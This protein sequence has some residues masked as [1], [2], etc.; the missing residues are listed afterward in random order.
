[1]PS[2]LRLP[3]VRLAGAVL[4]ISA[5]LAAAAPAAPTLPAV[6]AA[7]EQVLAAKEV[8]GAV[9]VV[10]TKDRVLHAGASGLA[11]LAEKKPMPEDAL[12]WIASVSKMV[13]GAAILALQ[14]EGRLKLGDPVAKYLPEFAAL[15]TPS[16][17]PANLTIAQL[18][19][20]T[21]GLAETPRALY[22][23]A[24]SLAEAVAPLATL[25]M[26]FEPEARWKYTTSGFDVAG[27]IAEAVTGQP[28]DRF[29]AARITGPLGMKDTTFFPTAEQ[30]A[31]LA[32]C[33]ARN[34]TTGELDF[35]PPDAAMFAL[36]RIPLPGGGLFSTA[37]DLGRFCQML[38]G[39][40]AFG[41]RRILSADAVAAL[42][43]V[44]TGDLATGYSGGQTNQ[45]LGWGA[46]VYVVR[47]PAARGVSAAL[48]PGAYGHPGAW[49]THAIVDP[50]RGLAYVLMVQRPNLPDNFENEPTRALVA[51]ATAA[52]KGP[53]D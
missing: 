47:T 2:A 7:M 23:T 31:R 32:S 6:S 29:L 34:R 33:Y 48:G 17:Q 3:R 41:G 15:R 4:L 53:K 51:A 27:R 40:G 30:K 37:G 8:A 26:Q 11:N 12:F 46:G 52:A 9:T 24:Q 42:A 50:A 22:G 44:R 14:D 49:G 28:F 43:T 20:H 19:A 35:R 1:M 10:V 21:S 38:L 5:W 18:L 13:T 45:V 25:P 39:G 36:G 16:G